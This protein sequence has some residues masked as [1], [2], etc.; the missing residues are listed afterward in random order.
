MR[1][2]LWRLRD[3]RWGPNGLRVE[4]AGDPAL[5]ERFLHPDHGEGPSSLVAIRAEAAVARA[6]PDQHVQVV[7][8]LDGRPVG[9]ATVHLTGGPLGIAGIY[10]VA[11][12]PAYRNRGIGKAVT[13][14]ACRVAWQ[15]GQAVAG[16]NATPLG[17]LVYRRL[18]FEPAGEG[19]TWELPSEV[20]AGPPAPALVAFAEAVAAGDLAEL[21]RL[22]V[23]LPIEDFD[24]PLACG[25]TP[26]QLAV[27]FQQRDAA[28]WLRRRGATV[29]LLSAWDLGWRKRAIRLLAERPELADEPRG[30]DRST[31]LHDAVERGDVELASLLLAAG[32]DP[33]VRDGAFDATPL[34]WA[35]HLRRPE[36]IELLDGAGYGR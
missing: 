2:D 21:D 23:R 29:D 8:W 11:V 15:R 9:T 6:L 3:V 1:L 12:L 16:L 32:A 34:D 30:L 22:D 13:T 20:L 14:A 35:H 7:A 25:L 36:L 28:E 27:R 24:R 10:G 19:Q 4:A 31:P 18:G 17:E 26:V 33:T 5:W